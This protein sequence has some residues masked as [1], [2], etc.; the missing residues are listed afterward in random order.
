MPLDS[1]FT[2]PTDTGSPRLTCWLLVRWRRKQEGLSGS[3]VVRRCHSRWQVARVWQRRSAICT[4][5]HTRG[6]LPS[7]ATTDTCSG[8]FILA[9]MSDSGLQSSSGPRAWQDRRIPHCAQG[10]SASSTVIVEPVVRVAACA[11]SPS[12]A[13]Y[14]CSRSATSEE[15]RESKEAAQAHDADAV[16]PAVALLAGYADLDESRLP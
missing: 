2:T 12:A 10:G 8:S 3:G 16:D 5:A 11:S 15:D 4:S 13:R 7:M 6:R 1:T 14:R 9:T